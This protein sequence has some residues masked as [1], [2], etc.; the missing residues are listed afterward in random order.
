MPTRAELLLKKALPYAHLAKDISLETLKEEVAEGLA[1]ID[2][3]RHMLFTSNEL[4][5][6]EVPYRKIRALHL[7]D[8][9][10]MFYKFAV[11]GVVPDF[12]A[13]FGNDVDLETAICDF[14]LLCEHTG[15]NYEEYD[16]G[17]FGVQPL[18]VHAMAVLRY[19]LSFSH[20]ESLHDTSNEMWLLDDEGDLFSF[21]ELSILAMMSEK[22]VRNAAHLSRP[23]GQRLKTIHS[24]SGT[25]ISR[26][27]AE[28]WLSKRRKFKLTQPFPSKQ[29][30]Q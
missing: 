20:I 2:N 7:C 13:R 28:E 16:V 6:E 21:K 1:T 10:E 12:K 15:L 22:S 24:G 9:A 26:E 5:E 19:R 14:G 4:Y 8:I 11:E 29:G 25:F 23:E 3:A 18:L 30:E 17:S 27:D